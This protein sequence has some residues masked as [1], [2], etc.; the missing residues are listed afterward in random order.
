M[1]SLLDDLPVASIIA[2]IVVITGAVVCITNPDTL[3]F[4]DFLTKLGIFL[5]GLGVLGVARSAGGKG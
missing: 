2:V 4:S 5:G 1:V 3:S